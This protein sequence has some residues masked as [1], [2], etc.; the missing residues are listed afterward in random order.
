[1][2]DKVTTTT[3]KKKPKKIKEIIAA[4]E[5]GQP[6]DDDDDDPWG[7]MDAVTGFNW[8]AK[9][10]TFTVVWSKAGSHEEKARLVLLDKP[11]KCM[12]IL[13]R[14][15]RNN[16]RVMNW[17]NN[18]KIMKKR[19][20]GWVDI[21]TYAR[22]C[23]WEGSFEVPIAACIN[24]IVDDKPVGEKQ[25]GR[26]EQGGQGMREKVDTNCSVCFVVLFENTD[27]HVDVAGI[28]CN[29]GQDL[30]VV[31]DEQDGSAVIG[32]QGGVGGAEGE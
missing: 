1:V 26:E 15:H 30:A 20:E 4:E 28:D 32:K 31:N 3:Q 6:D 7:E 13:W 12:K 25:P 9:S 23:Q 10:P 18:L 16:L 17:I 22:H 2:K 14:D 27:I 8:S 29:E 19:V 21:E 24:A 11:R 5:E